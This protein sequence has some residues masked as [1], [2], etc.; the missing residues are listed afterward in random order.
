MLGITLLTVGGL[1][2]GL[3]FAGSPTKLAAGA[4]IAGV[5][6]GGL[7]PVQAETR[8]Q[9]RF[10][11][12]EDSPVVF[13]AGGESWR[14]TPHKLGVH[15]DWRAAVQT[16]KR[17]GDGFA[18]VRGLRRI[19]MRVFG[20]DIAPPTR[21]YGAA[22]RYQ[23]TLLARDVDRPQREAA[24]RLRGLDVVTVPA[25]SGR[26]LDR[27]KAESVLVR[28]LSS[29][30]RTPVALPLRSRPAEVKAKDL[31]RVAAQARTALSAP[32]RL[33]L[34]PTKWRLPRWRI[35][36]LLDLPREGR[37]TL[38]IG[39]PGADRYF[40]RFRKRVD[41]PPANADF[42]VTEGGIR[43]VP[44]REGMVVDGATTKAALLAALLSESDRVARVTVVRKA[45]E[46]ST[47][48]ARAMRITGLVGSY[49]TI[50][51]G[52]PN[53]IHNVQLVSR[54][55]DRTL[56]P[57]G[58]T[59]SFNETTGERTEEKG[60]RE[61]PVIINGE[62]ENGLGGGVCQVSTTV[63]NAAYEAGLG[64][65]ARTNHALYIDHYP[66]ARDATV[67]YPDLDLRFVN[68][69]PGWLLV[70]TFV[71]P[72]SLTVNLYGTP[73][74]RR[75]E[76]ETAPLVTTGSIPTKKVFDS[77][78]F[79]GESLLEEAG[80]PPRSTSVRRRVYSQ[81]GKL[82]HED[83]WSSYYRSEEAVYR[84]G[85][86][87]KPTPEPKPTPTPTPEPKPPPETTTTDTTTTPAEPAEGREP[88]TPTP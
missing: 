65:T 88:D 82:L 37:R 47:A 70:R 5:Q 2:L 64:I 29:L 76:S 20:A 69:T 32:V 38:A 68:D 36:G 78:L 74:N 39:G 67:N 18:P 19:G 16:A 43:L 55:I 46:R 8:L 25:R 66:L 40:T 57:P 54:L 24:L 62:L 28:A 75:V 58:T 77:D 72:S 21:V 63:F 13:T 86:K 71:G 15:V 34:G 27:R 23:L 41:R 85:T 60:F 49:T 87:P 9:R 50:Y 3:S 73:V 22:L 81:A 53:R 11:R 59:F 6:V 7:T 52:E 33:S 79:V 56:I 35:A 17:E 14:I 31:V 84:V 1:A 44:A 10:A 48:E 45:A 26:T 51:G 42:A 61:A 83:A 4:T 30:Q 80:A 12:L